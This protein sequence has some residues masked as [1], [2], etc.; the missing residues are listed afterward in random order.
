LCYED[1][2]H[3][4]ADGD[5]IPAE[6]DCDD[7]DEN[8]VLET[9]RVC[10]SACDEGTQM[11]LTDGTWS[12]CS[13]ETT[14]ECNEPGAIREHECG[15]CGWGYQHCGSDYQWGM[16]DEC[17]DQGECR[18]GE[19]GD[20]EC[21]FCGSQTRMCDTQCNWLDW[22]ECANPGECI[23]G[24]I[25]GTTDDCTPLGAIR[26]IACSDA[27][28]WEDSGECFTD[29]EGIAREGTVDASGFYDYKDEICISAG[30][31]YMGTDSDE[32]YIRPK[33]RPMH[34]V[35]LSPYFIDKYEVTRRR[36]RECIEAGACVAVGDFDFFDDDYHNFPAIVDYHSAVTFC[37]WDGGRVLP[38]EAEWMKAARGPYPRT[39]M[40]PWGDDLAVCT[41]WSMPDCLSNSGMQSVEFWADRDESYYGAIQM[42]YGVAEITADRYVEDY[43]LTCEEL[44]PYFENDDSMFTLRGKHFGHAS[45]T[46][47]SI[48]SRVGVSTTFSTAIGFRCAKVVY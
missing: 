24:T 9:V 17:L 25:S 1:V 3:T 41:D 34:I 29:C 32:Y 22:S 39:V 10:T 27:C 28:V 35:Y 42:G 21:G 26:H 4:D 16:V 40:H 12:T 48:L 14:C 18:P 11:C 19:E 31:F 7:T 2:C 36:Y 30:P 47:Y 37:E 20:Q 43:H 45:S 46:E 13:A 15:N 33:H 8:V 44:N 38:T 6:L 23:P 5:G